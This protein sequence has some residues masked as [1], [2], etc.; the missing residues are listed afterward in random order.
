LTAAEVGLLRAADAATT[1]SAAGS[2]D[3][4][5]LDRAP[6]TLTNKYVTHTTLIKHLI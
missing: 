4:P 6:A 3:A 2:L 1:A 5:E